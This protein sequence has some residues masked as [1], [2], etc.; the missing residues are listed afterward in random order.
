MFARDS[1]GEAVSIN[2]NFLKL[3]KA[4][5]GCVL[6]NEV[7]DI[8]GGDIFVLVVDPSIL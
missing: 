4:H 1:G 2:S 6:D 3:L 7:R 5:V 8:V